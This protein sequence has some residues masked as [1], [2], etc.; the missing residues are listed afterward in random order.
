MDLWMGSL[1]AKRRE[2]QEPLKNSFSS[3][4]VT[5]S[6]ASQI[7]LRNKEVFLNSSRRVANTFRE[8]KKRR[9]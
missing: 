4:Q 7:N 2:P 9:L 1:M 6:L 3:S 8:G 5:V